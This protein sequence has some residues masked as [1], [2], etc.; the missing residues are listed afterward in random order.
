MILGVLE[1]LSVIGG[2]TEGASVPLWC[3]EGATR[4]AGQRRTPRRF[5]TAEAAGDTAGPGPDR[6]PNKNET[7]TFTHINQRP[8]THAR[9]HTHVGPSVISL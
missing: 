6:E 8:C 5:C 1:E 4:P 3:T 2:E 7:H 9:T